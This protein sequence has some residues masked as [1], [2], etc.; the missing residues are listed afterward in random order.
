LARKP[1][2]SPSRPRADFPICSAG[3]RIL[4]EYCR[5]HLSWRRHAARPVCHRMP[6]CPSC[7]LCLPPNCHRTRPK[8][9]K[10]RPHRPGPDMPFWAFL[11]GE[12]GF[13]PPAPLLLLESR[14]SARR[15][16]CEGVPMAIR[17][18]GHDPRREAHLGA[19]DSVRPSPTNA[20]C[21][22]DHKEV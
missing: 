12:G 5:D 6:F 21:A 16:V 8:D 17:G 7:S 19:V 9:A 13:E 1:R 10:A 11:S 18:R 14:L 2:V 4:P 20:R 15:L 3:V 22:P